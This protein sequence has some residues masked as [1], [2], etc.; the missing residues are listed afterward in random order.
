MLL[1]R[2]GGLDLKTTDWI[3]FRFGPQDPS[4]NGRRHVV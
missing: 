1:Q 3:V 4:R 2:F